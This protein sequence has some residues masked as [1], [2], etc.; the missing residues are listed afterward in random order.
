MNASKNYYRLIVVDL[1]RQRELDAN[2]KAIQ[3]IGFVAQLENPADAIVVGESMFL[4]TILEKSR[5]SKGSVTVLQK[6]TSH[7]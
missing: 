1:K 6:I 3:Q 5:F 7:E 2:P 4:S